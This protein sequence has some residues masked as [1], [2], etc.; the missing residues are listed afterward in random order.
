MRAGGLCMRAGA[1]SHGM[2]ALAALVGRRMAL[3]VYVG[4]YIRNVGPRAVW[5][6]GTCAPHGRACSASERH[7]RAVHR[8]AVLR[9]V[10]N[11]KVSP[12]VACR[13]TARPFPGAGAAPAFACARP[14]SALATVRFAACF[15]SVCAAGEAHLPRSWRVPGYAAG[16]AQGAQLLAAPIAPRAVCQLFR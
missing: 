6:C 8:C 10:F 7:N 4:P 2:L 1:L 3:W 11:C 5:S 15:C 9:V 14:S 16:I 12:R 13:V